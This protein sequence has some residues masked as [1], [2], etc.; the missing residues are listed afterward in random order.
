MTSAAPPD[1]PG[2][3]RVVGLMTRAA[4]RRWR[5]RLRSHF[6][7]TLRLR[8]RRMPGAARQATGRRMPAGPL[9]AVFFGLLFFYA[10]VVNSATLIGNLADQLDARSLG[11]PGQ[12]GVT[13]LTYEAIERT[14]E[15]LRRAGPSG[16][17]TPGQAQAAAS[18][19]EI[20]LDALAL[21]FK[22]EAALAARTTQ[23]R[24]ELQALYM[25]TFSETGAA[26]FFAAPHRGQTFW[27]SRALWPQ[28]DNRPAMIRAVG[29]LMA[30]IFVTLVFM[31]LA[32]QDLGKVGWTVEWLFTLPV[33]GRSLMLAQLAQLAILNPVAWV[34]TLAMTTAILAAAGFGLMALVA[35]LVIALGMN[36]MVAS[37]RLVAE[38]W[39]RQRLPHTR[40]KNYQAL[41]AIFGM[42]GLMSLF[43]L[44]HMRTFPRGL[45]D[46][47]ATSSDWMLL[48][49]P[50]LPALACEHGASVALVLAYLTASA[51]VVTIASVLA[52]ARLLRGGLL[53][54]SCELVGARK[55]AAAGRGIAGPFRGV[56]G[57]E[58]RLLL[59]DRT[60]LAQTVVVPMLM[61]VFQLLVDPM[62]LEGAEGDCR[63]AAALA[64]GIGAYVLATSGVRV[65]A[66]E[67]QALWLLYALPHTLDKVL[68]RKALLWAFIAAAY[69]LTILGATILSQ[70]WTDPAVSVDVAMALAGVFIYAFIA[71][72]IGILASDPLDNEP[73][74][75]V[76]ASYLCLY[77]MLAGLYAYGIYAPS[78]WQ[79]GAQVVLCALVAV[80]IWMKV[81]ERLPY[82]LDPSPTPPPR[83]GA[84]DGLIV[85]FA[86]YSVQGLLTLALKATPGSGDPAEQQ[87]FACT[88]A[89]ALVA[90]AAAAVFR[91]R[92][93]APVPLMKVGWIRT[94]LTGTAWGGAAILF[95]F[96]HTAAARSLPWLSMAGTEP[97]SLRASFSIETAWFAFLMVLGAPLFEEYLYRGLLLRGLLGSLSP[98]LA[99][100]ASATI[101]TLCHPPIAVLT[102][103]GLGLATAMSYRMTGRLTAPILTHMIYN[104]VILAAWAAA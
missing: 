20:E 74:P 41:A 36:L 65:L 71:S 72:G 54:Q 40:L 12:L 78:L 23:E 56:V 88:M 38:T 61:V 19:R 21:Y 50:S 76:G 55:G 102:V 60:Y 58:I 66:S 18:F 7:A 98:A 73:V 62:I 35:A 85:V 81:R 44:P 3:G 26:G 4:L 45:L 33:S 49:P 90:L 22:G 31:S 91:L 57:K 1:P 70:P 77:L 64:F 28:A 24:Q 80:A 92:H 97:I 34:L 42:L 29:L 2:A 83:I 86:F 51:I 100:L 75:K 39:L 14:E 87:V 8:R 47:L 25:K 95:A 94:L 52:S 63:H 32:S 17:P 82:L 68:R 101:F 48:F 16:S 15:F 46:W 93:Q 99:V 11:R 67:G 79:K 69:T 9:L 37:V 27:P 103:F 30:W 84:S 59:R 89:G 5:H 53:Q 96:F 13:Q 104:A 6:S 10:T 43:I